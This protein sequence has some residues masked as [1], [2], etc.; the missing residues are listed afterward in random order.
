MN[1]FEAF[2]LN[3]PAVEIQRRRACPGSGKI[4][5][6]GMDKTSAVRLIETYLASN[7]PE[8]ALAR[9]T[10]DFVL[11]NEN[12]RRRT[13]LAGHV[14]A[15]AW[16]VDDERT[17]VALVHHRAL[18]R[19]LQPGGHI[20]DDDASLLD[21]SLRE[22]REETGLR[23]IAP[24]KAE[25][26]DI[27]VHPIPQSPRAPA[28]LHYDIRFLLCAEVEPLTVSDESHDVRWVA[29]DQI[30]RLCADASLARMAA[31]TKS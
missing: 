24:I 12:W 13:N 27:D 28:H 25:I 5:E 6:L 30:S 18:G 23:R 19:W 10:L 16:I 7:P 9:Q 1:S 22:A 29:L 4:L 26:F 20:E 8:W 15:S 21:A 2:A 31:K 14:T 17:R 3:D 11:G